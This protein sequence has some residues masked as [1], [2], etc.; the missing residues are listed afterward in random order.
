MTSLYFKN[1]VLFLPCFKVNTQNYSS[2]G[3]SYYKAELFFHLM[4]QTI[5]LKEKKAN[6]EL[7]SAL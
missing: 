7:S 4:K 6:T 3:F 5:I 1:Y 2:F